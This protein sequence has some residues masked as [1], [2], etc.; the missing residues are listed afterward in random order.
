MRNE[1]Q[2]GRTFEY[3]MGGFEDGFAV[4]SVDGFQALLDRQGRLRTS[5][6]YD[7]IVYPTQGCFWVRLEDRCGIVDLEE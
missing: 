2:F 6:P 4:V 1:I 7:D 5:R 3:I